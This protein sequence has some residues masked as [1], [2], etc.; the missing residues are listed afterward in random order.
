MAYRIGA[1][2]IDTREGRIAQVVGGE[3]KRTRVQRP[4]G[5]LEWEVPFSAL[6]LATREEREAAGIRSPA[7]CR[8]CAELEAGQRSSVSSGS[9]ARAI[10]ATIALARHREQAHTE[11][12]ENASWQ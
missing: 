10:N 4:G 9:R 3:G 6:R 1:Y 12:K 11:E 2:V 7:G 5:G 8:T